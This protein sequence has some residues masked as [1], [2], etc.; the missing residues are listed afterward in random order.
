MTGVLTCALPISASTTALQTL[1]TPETVRGASPSDARGA[2]G[3]EIGRRQTLRL[4]FLSRAR[5]GSLGFE[6]TGAD[7]LAP[8][9]LG[10]IDPRPDRGFVNEFKRERGVPTESNRSARRAR[11]SGH[12]TRISHGRGG[13][14]RVP[15]RPAN[16]A[17]RFPS[18]A[19]L[20]TPRRTG[21]ASVDRRLRHPSR[22][23]PSRDR[24][25]TRPP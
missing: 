24:A 5:V 23:S 3:E 2:R 13:G 22:L 15:A 20:S 25:P 21:R 1:E 11:V 10:R 19:R 9:G 12:P 18:R 4:L 6:F 16:V 17:V 8:R 14:P 7:R